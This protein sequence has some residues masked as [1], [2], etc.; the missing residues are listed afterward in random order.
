MK[1]IKNILSIA[2]LALLLQSCFLFDRE[3][4][5]RTQNEELDNRFSSIK[6]TWSITGYYINGV[7][8]YDT[9]RIYNMHFP[10]VFDYKPPPLDEYGYTKNFQIFQIA[11]QLDS[12]YLKEKVSLGSY[13]V[14][15]NNGIGGWFINSTSFYYYP[16]DTLLKVQ[17]EKTIF[18]NSL[19]KFE[20]HK[21]D[22]TIYYAEMYGKIN[23]ERYIKL[24]RNE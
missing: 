4:V 1:S 19:V 11:P 23:F 14:G 6:G 16:N 2:F 20:L 8:H 5:S 15:G 18:G 22:M 9:V 10:I 17:Y 12:V 3:P 24:K 13:F 7:S 21:N